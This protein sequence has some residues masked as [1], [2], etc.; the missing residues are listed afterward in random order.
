MRSM[1]SKSFIKVLKLVGQYGIKE[2]FSCWIIKRITNGLVEQS[3][4]PIK[5]QQNSESS[6]QINFINF[7][8]SYIPCTFIIVKKNICMEQL[9]P[10]N[11]I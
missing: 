11:K 5:N 10:S 1:D 9:V 8:D 4:F 6:F 2:I 7:P 3:E